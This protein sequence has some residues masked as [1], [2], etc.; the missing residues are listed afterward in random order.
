M[1]CAAGLGCCGSDCCAVDES[2]WRG[3][4]WE[5][6]GASLVTQGCDLPSVGTGWVFVVDEFSGAVD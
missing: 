1:V 2:L 4:A 3:A 5:C 6:G